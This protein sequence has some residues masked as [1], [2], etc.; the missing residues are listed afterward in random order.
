MLEDS[1]ERQLKGLFEAEHQARVRNLLV[2]HC[3]QNLPFAESL[4]KEGIARV[5]SAVIKLSDGDI[6]R[7]EHEIEL[8]GKDWRDT[9]MKSGAIKPAP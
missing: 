2:D 7:L 8:A 9:L 6:K 1:V 3:G 4:G 5:Q